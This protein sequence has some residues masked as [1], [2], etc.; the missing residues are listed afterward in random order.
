[1]YFFKFLMPS[2][3]FL[4]SHPLF[5]LSYLSFFS[6]HSSWTGRQKLK[7]KK[8]LTT[9]H[10]Y[11]SLILIYKPFPLPFFLFPLPLELFSYSPF[12]S[13]LFFSF[14][15]FF[16]KFIPFPFRAL[17]VITYTLFSGVIL[18]GLRSNWAQ[19]T[20]NYIFFESIPTFGVLF[21]SLLAGIILSFV[22]CLFFFLTRN[23]RFYLTFLSK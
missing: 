5:F 22:F 13:F 8:Y 4:Y 14:L 18:L 3:A 10:R 6:S 15:F 1:M 21:L 7:I 20:K 17:A 19:N 16:D 12:F 23:L 2:F 11:F 9:T